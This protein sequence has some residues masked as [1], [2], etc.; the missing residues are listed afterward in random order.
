MIISKDERTWAMLAHLSSFLGYLVGGVGGIIG[1]LVVWLI[2][3]DEAPFVADQARES[4]N[5][6]LSLLLYTVALVASCFLLIGFV[7]IWFAVPFLAILGLVL[8]IVGGVK[9]N[10]GHAYR[11]PM[12]IRFIK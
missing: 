9:A 6:Q 5:F 4:L 1:P 7:L 3:K 8:P 11:Y 10:E 12:T 2:K